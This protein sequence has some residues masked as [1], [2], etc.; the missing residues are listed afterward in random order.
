[1]RS[2]AAGGKHLEGYWHKGFGG[3]RPE[4]W[5]DKA[6]QLHELEEQV[7]GGAYPAPL[8][9]IASKTCTTLG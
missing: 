6:A 1:M 9:M 3:I 7:S 8:L 5:E 4:D 2:Q